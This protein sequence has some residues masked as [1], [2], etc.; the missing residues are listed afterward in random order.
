MLQSHWQ[1]DRTATVRMI[2]DPL[3]ILDMWEGMQETQT[4]LQKA[5]MLMKPGT[6][7]LA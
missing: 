3:K 5:G 4:P 6:C 1:D 7:L 2:S